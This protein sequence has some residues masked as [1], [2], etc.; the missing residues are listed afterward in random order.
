[1][2][3]HQTS[4]NLLPYW[5]LSSFYFFYFA[6]LG[7]FAPFFTLYLDGMLAC[8]KALPFE[9]SVI[10]DVNSWLGRSQFT[11]DV[12]FSGSIEEFRI[13]DVALTASQVAFSYQ[14]GPDPEFL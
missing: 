5:R 6:Y 10:D 7:T 1:M 13:Y 2:T 3:V 11:T 14:A 9:L 4:P 12:G 8:A